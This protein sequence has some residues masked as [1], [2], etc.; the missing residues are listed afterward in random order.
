MSFTGTWNGSMPSITKDPV[1]NLDYTVDWSLYLASYLDTIDSVVW[2]AT[3]AGLTLGA[4]SKG[5]TDATIWLSGGAAGV[6]YSVTCRITTVGGRVTERTF[7]V[8]CQNR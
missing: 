5:A 4:N 3:P 1:D 7:A 2:S 8:I 6:T